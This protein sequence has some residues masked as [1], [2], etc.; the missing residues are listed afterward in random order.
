M[1]RDEYERDICARSVAASSVPFKPDIV[2]DGWKPKSGQCHQNVDYWVTCHPGHTAVRGWI[3][4]Y[5]GGGDLSVYT[6][7]SVV[8]A[9]DGEL[10]DI[11]PLDNGDRRRGPFIMHRANDEAFLMPRTQN[12]SISCQ[13]DYPTPPFD[14][15]MAAQ[16]HES[17]GEW[18]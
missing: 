16:Q 9:A 12:L 3:F 15:F 4:W 7:H 2:I 13:R 10:F 5:S 11:T 1:T 8:R 14:L 17:D 6:A 18:Q